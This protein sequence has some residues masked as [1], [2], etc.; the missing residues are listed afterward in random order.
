M[1]TQRARR[2][3]LLKRAGRPWPTRLNLIPMHV[4]G[5]FG[6]DVIMPPEKGIKIEKPPWNPV[7]P[8]TPGIQ[9]LI[10]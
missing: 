9:S 10:G 6:A 4:E 5:T 2:F 3:H 8:N 7:R 1:L